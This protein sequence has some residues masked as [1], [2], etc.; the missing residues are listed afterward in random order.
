[1]TCCNFGIFSLIA[2]L[3]GS[4]EESRIQA[5]Q[6]LQE[7]K[8]E[9]E[10]ILNTVADGITAQDI[11]GR[12]IF[13]NVAAAQLTGYAS[14]D[15]IKT[16]T[17]TDLQRK[18]AMFDEQANPLPFSALPRHEVFKSG[19]SASRTFKMRFVD[20][21]E[22]K[23]IDLI[24]A[25][26]FDEQGKVKLVVNVL[27]DIT[28]Q[29][30]VDQLRTR[31]E[32]IVQNSN[33]AIISK[34]LDRTILSW[35]PGAERLYGY[36]ANEAIGQ[37]I[38]ML[39]PED[40]A[41]HELQLT[42]RIQQGAAVKHYETRRLQKQ[43]NEVEIELTISPIRD[44]NGQII[45]Y[46][47]IERDITERNRLNRQLDQE[48]RR[49]TTILNTIPGIVFEGSGDE[50]AGT[51]QI[52]YISNYA[53]TLLGYSLEELKATPN[54]WKQVIHPDDWDHAVDHA[55]ETYAQNIPGPVK[56]RCIT[57]DGRTLH[58]ES[59]N[60]II[61]NYDERRIGTCGLVLDVTERRR[62]EQEIM[63]LTT[64]ID[65][66]R[67]RLDAIIHNLPG[68]IFDTTFD[69]ERGEQ[70][71]NLMSDYAETML[72]YSPEK[73]HD[74]PGFWQQII[75]PMTGNQRWRRQLPLLKIN[76]LAPASFVVPMPMVIPYL[77]SHFSILCK[78][79]HRCDSLASLWTFLNASKSKL[80]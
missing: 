20:T 27:R 14:P 56:F 17:V 16:S 2:F 25:P 75:H 22:E 76:V 72:G 66:Q 58:V 28:L 48:R 31:Y 12:P 32:A 40:I 8:E 5:H 3:I 45:G 52:D 39:F 50:D 73:W 71:V 33:D 51:Q 78:R 10:V 4:L 61:T 77:P 35:N 69:V 24:A 11:D 26:V 38:S 74:D 80:S 19:K 55:N 21:G 13:A 37:H 1:M 70:S 54:F 57:Q 65:A 68:I 9:L 46:S 41:A 59:Y 62:R 7:I 34:A 36:T 64:I 53:E 6:S 47:T 30:E 79:V 67:R 18:Y 42:E 23:W 29:R 15:A 44:D 43:G 49:L 60:A 63:Q